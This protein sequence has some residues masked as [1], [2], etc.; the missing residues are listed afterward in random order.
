MLKFQA[1]QRILSPAS[2]RPAS[3]Q[4][5]KWK[6]KRDMALVFVLCMSDVTLESPT[7]DIMEL[8]L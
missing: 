4:K 2:S 8:S 6:E 5:R 7:D 3:Y 1:H